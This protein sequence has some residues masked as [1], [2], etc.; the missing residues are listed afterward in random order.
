MFPLSSTLSA[1]RACARFTFSR[2]TM[3]FMNFTLRRFGTEFC[4]TA[5]FCDEKGG[6]TRFGLVG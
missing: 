4:K 6:A 3:N 2:E 1:V 5:P